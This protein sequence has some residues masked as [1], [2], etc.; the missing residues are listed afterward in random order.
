MINDAVVDELA[1]ISNVS[2]VLILVRLVALKTMSV[3][4][5]FSLKLMFISA[6]I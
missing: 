2:K 1:D 6:K 4:I 3:L 5:F